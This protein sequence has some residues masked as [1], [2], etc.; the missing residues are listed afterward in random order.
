MPGRE[1]ARNVLTSPFD[2]LADSSRWPEIV[3]WLVEQQLSLRRAIEAVGGVNAIR[4]LSS[5]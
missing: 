4:H 5:V 1:G 2:D 3:S